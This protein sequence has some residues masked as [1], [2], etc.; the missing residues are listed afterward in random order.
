LSNCQEHTKSQEYA[1]MKKGNTRKIPVALLES[2]LVL[3]PK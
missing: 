3:V 1:L 2:C